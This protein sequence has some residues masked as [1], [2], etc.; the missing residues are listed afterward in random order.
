MWPEG[1]ARATVT[2]WFNAARSEGERSPEAVL[3]VVERLLGHKWDWS[4]TLETRQLC[5]TG[6]AP[7][8]MRGSAAPAKFEAE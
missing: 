7:F 6:S 8:S 1:S 5:S 3:Q 2:A 4:T